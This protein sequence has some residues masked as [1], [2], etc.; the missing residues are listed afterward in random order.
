MAWQSY[1]VL[2]IM[3]KLFPKF[4][5]LKLVII[6]VTVFEE[7]LQKGR[8]KHKDILEFVKMLNICLKASVDSHHL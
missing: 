3:T 1:L 2:P 4:S 5:K 8:Y 7:Y 6:Y